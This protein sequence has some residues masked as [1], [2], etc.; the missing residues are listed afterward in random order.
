MVRRSGEAKHRVSRRFGF[1]VYGT[2]GA[3]LRRRLGTP[4]GVTRRRRRKESRYGEQLIE[5]QKVKA[6]YGVQERAFRRQLEAASLQA[7]PTGENLLTR[8]ER[9]LDN[10]VYRL[11]FA[12]SRPMARQLVGHGHVLVD[13]ARLTIPSAL[14]AVGQRISLDRAAASIPAVQESIARGPP[15]TGLAH[16]GGTGSGRRRAGRAGRPARRARGHR[17]AD[18]RAPGR[19]VLRSLTA[20]LRPAGPAADAVADCIAGARAR[21]SGN[22]AFAAH[23]G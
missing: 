1:D 19:G 6:I 17:A 10:T 15:R 23:L 5:K 8:L 9:R 2:G 11:G 3:S 20:V 16:P 21:P 13:G 14:V 4:P 18:R 22:G 7:G 12:K